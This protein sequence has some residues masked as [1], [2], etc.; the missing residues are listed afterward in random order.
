MSADQDCQSITIQPKTSTTTATLYDC[1]D[2]TKNSTVPEFAESKQ[3]PEE[4][5]MRVTCDPLAVSSQ[6]G[7]S[8]TMPTTG[9]TGTINC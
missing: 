4:T 7:W 8:V 1:P 3:P 6:S 9:L 5:A 2:R